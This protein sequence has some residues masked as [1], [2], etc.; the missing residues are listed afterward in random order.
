ME[1]IFYPEAKDCT[2]GRFDKP[3]VRTGFFIIARHQEL[4]KFGEAFRMCSVLGRTVDYLCDFDYRR[5]NIEVMDADPNDPP[6][7]N[8][9]EVVLSVDRDFLLSL[10]P[11]SEENPEEC[12]QRDIRQMMMAASAMMETHPQL[13]FTWMWEDTLSIISGLAEAMML[14]M[15]NGFPMIDRFGKLEAEDNDEHEDFEMILKA[16]RKLDEE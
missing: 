4:D 13:R 6:E 11:D 1:I 15:I 8:I 10:I 12:V 2:I 3:Y 7:E 14:V 16:L 5:C 9:M